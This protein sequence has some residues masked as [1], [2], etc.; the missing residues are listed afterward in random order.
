MS[1]IQGRDNEPLRGRNNSYRNHFTSLS[2]KLKYIRIYHT[3]VEMG[4]NNFG[5]SVITLLAN[6]GIL[7]QLAYDFGV[8]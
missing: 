2:E 1:I 7:Q 3:V 5:V 8:L 6:V 4:P